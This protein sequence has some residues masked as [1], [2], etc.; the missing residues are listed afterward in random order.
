LKTTDGYLAKETIPYKANIG[1]ADVNLGLAVS[2]PGG[3]KAQA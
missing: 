1:Y 3:G 2:S